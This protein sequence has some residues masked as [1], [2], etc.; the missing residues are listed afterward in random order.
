ML[1]DD[2]AKFDRLHAAKIE[3]FLSECPSFESIDDL[4]LNVV[5]MTTPW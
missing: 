1:R 5:Q 4:Y 2:P 3:V